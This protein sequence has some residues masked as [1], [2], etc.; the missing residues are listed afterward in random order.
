M[1]GFSINDGLGCIE[2]DS[3]NAGSGDSKPDDKDGS[4]TATSTS[5][6][7]ADL[8]GGGIG[9]CLVIQL[10]AMMQRLTNDRWFATPHRVLCPPTG[11]ASERL[12]L[13]FFF[14]PNAETPLQLPPAEQLAEPVAA[15][16]AAQAAAA[17]PAAAAAAATATGQ[18]DNHQ[19]QYEGY[20]CVT[21]LEFV[22]Q[23]NRKERLS[24]EV[25]P[26][27]QVILTALSS[28]FR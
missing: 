14:R 1:H 16:R 25:L 28:K 21:A 13:A 6:V 17:S 22:T 3:D 2:T 8:G 15:D 4:E 9:G 26:E 10:G 20:D 5:G 23:L 24:V 19:E 12:T 7:S 18:L 27:G 11:L